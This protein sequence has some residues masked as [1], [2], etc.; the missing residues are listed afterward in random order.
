VSTSA[1]AFL[2]D[3]TLDID[4]S[5]DE[6]YED[7]RQ[8]GRLSGPLFILILFLILILQVFFI[9]WLVSNGAI[10]LDGFFGD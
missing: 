9:G 3:S 7:E 8:E 1:D 6:F 4:D 2:T 10:P 5:E